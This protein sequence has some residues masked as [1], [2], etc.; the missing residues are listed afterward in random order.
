MLKM[1]RSKEKGNRTCKHSWLR[2]GSRKG[3]AQPELK[4]IRFKEKATKKESLGHPRARVSQTFPGARVADNFSDPGNR[5]R[6]WGRLRKLGSGRRGRRMNFRT[7]E[8]EH[9]V[10]ER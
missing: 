9:A 5:A 3:G 7:P 2:L 4:M 10:G 6:R 8:M 1:I